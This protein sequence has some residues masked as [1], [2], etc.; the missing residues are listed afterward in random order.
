MMLAI[1][2][3]QLSE[4]AVT[5]YEQELIDRSGG[6]LT[7]SMRRMFDTMLNRASTV[8]DITSSVDSYDEDSGKVAPCPPV[9]VSDTRCP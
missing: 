3:Q 1:C 6:S 2:F 9:E 7:L 8:A 4:E 5:S